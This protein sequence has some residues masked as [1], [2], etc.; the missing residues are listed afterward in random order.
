[1]A[2]TLNHTEVAYLRKKLGLSARELCDLMGIKS[3][4]DFPNYEAD[5]ARVK[6][7]KPM[8]APHCALLVLIAEYYHNY[9]RL[10]QLEYLKSANLDY[11]ARDMAE[12]ID[13]PTSAGEA[14]NWP[15][16]REIR[17]FQRREAAK[18]AKKD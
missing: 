3:F 8:P 4:R 14:E 9:R 6:S 12:G 2:I 5:P 17:A 16:A 13:G 10:P 15:T 18:E 7:A 1:M 11:C